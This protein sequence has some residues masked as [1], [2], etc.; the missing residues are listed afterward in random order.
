M[1]KWLAFF[2]YH[3]SL[4]FDTSESPLCHAIHRA[5]LERLRRRIGEEEYEKWRAR[6]DSN[7]H[8]PDS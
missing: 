3:W 6:E 2:A 8:L 5:R 1:K 4:G 7:P